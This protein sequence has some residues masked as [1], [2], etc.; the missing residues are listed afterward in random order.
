MKGLLK[1]IKLENSV[2]VTFWKI[3]TIQ[4]NPREKC[5]T[6]SLG[7]YASEAA[8]DAAPSK[9]IVAPF[10]ECRDDD[11]DKYFA[12]DKLSPVGKEPEVNA[13]TWLKTQKSLRRIG[14]KLDLTTGVT[15]VP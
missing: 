6:I 13:Y 2:S 9:D 8:Y 3:M 15:D 7:G 5:V 4:I 11:Y 14:T 12:P 10:G 1:T